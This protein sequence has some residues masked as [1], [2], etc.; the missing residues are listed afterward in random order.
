MDHRADRP[1]RSLRIGNAERSDA[2]LVLQRAVAEGR[3]GTSELDERVESVQQARTFA[4]LD[5]VLADLPVPSPSSQFV[6][7]GDGEADNA[8]KSPANTAVALPTTAAP[9]P[10]PGFVEPG[11]APDDPMVVD[12]GWGNEVR[13]GRWEIPPYLQ[14]RGNVGTVMLNCLEAVSSEPVIYVE[15]MGGVGTITVVVP[16]GWAARVDRLAKSWGTVNAKVPTDP[17]GGRPLVVVTGS[18]GMGT[19][20]IRAANWFEKRAAAKNLR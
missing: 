8:Q 9:A 20:T 4:D 6:E 12:A 14:I 18:M 3:L 19:F 2:M 1:V 16:E 17:T 11:W 15:V 10:I 7:R 13:K 5:E